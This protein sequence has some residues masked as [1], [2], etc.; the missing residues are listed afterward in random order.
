MSDY[1]VVEL[2]GKEL[3]ESTGAPSTYCSAFPTDALSLLLPTTFNP[4]RLAE[5]LPGGALWPP[6]HRYKLAYVVSS[7]IHGIH[8]RHGDGSEGVPLNVRLLQGRLG[9]GKKDFAKLAIDTLCAWG[10]LQLRRERSS[11]RHARLYS[12]GDAF[13]GVPVEWK[14]FHA[15]RLVA[16]LAADRAIRVATVIDSDP[17]LTFLAANLDSVKLSETG[18]A[19]A[20]CRTFSSSEQQAAWL[21][22]VRALADCRNSIHV[23]PVAGR[24]YHAVANCPRDLRSF[25][26]LEGEPTAEVD[27]S[28]AQFFLLLDRYPPDSPE[29][30][31][32]GYVVTSGLFYEHL[33]KRLFERGEGAQ[34]GD[35]SGRLT[36][37]WKR[38]GGKAIRDSFKEHAIR[39]LLYEPLFPGSRSRGLWPVFAAEFPVLAGILASYRCTKKG[40]QQLNHEMQRL[41]V[42]LVLGRVMPRLQAECPEAKPITIH[43]AIL[44]KA[45]YAETVK[46]MMEEEG[47]ALVGVEPRVKIKSGAESTHALAQ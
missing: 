13:I 20:L 8:R 10:V 42:G 27:I 30:R 46:R 37:I 22:S 29:R 35:G 40:A 18:H 5:D 15:P 19:E 39:R 4:D 45:A 44:C 28:A 31:R 3:E 33:F 12:L 43:D 14:R 2:R 34:W 47:A 9:K 25:L 24:I 11:G 16:K 1:S 41:E 21:L 17:T 7:V 6:K 32:F 26:L 36:E 23:G 38:E